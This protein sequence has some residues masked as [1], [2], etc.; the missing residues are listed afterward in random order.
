M[1]LFDDMIHDK[2]NMAHNK[3]TVDFSIVMPVYFNE[4]SLFPTAEIFSKLLINRPD[5][6]VGEVIFVDDGSLDHSL[7][8]LILIQSRFLYSIK[9]IKLTRNFG[10]GPATRAG[11]RHAQGRCVIVISADEQDPPELINDML[12]GFFKEGYE[13]VICTRQDRDESFFRKMTSMIFY[14]LM[15]KLSFPTMP[16]GGF[17]YYLLGRRALYE[18]LEN[19]EYQPFIQGQI[20]WTGFNIKTIGYKRRSRKIGKSQFTFSKKLGLLLDGVLSFS[21]VPIRLASLFGVMVAL[22]GFCYAALVFVG[23]FL[24]GNPVQGWAPLM[25]VI[26]VLGGIQIIT[27]GLIGEYLWRTL[28]QVRNR[29]S[30]LIDCIYEQDKID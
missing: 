4:G 19:N 11:F 28:A 7:D 1:K 24:H 2:D 20:Y 16:K 30:Y 3:N 13:V 9:V 14:G 22:L 27:L 6:L 15:K 8:E 29:K 26:L 25:I 17:D 5:D 23:W 21:F 12:H 10:Q 18:I